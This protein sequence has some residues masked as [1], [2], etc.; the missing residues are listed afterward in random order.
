MTD[1]RTLI[2]ST[3]QVHD[4]ESLLDHVIIIDNSRVLLDSPI[5]DISRRYAFRYV[6]PQ[7]MDDSVIYAEPSLQGN[8]V[9]ML[10]GEGEEETQVNLE[11]LFNAT[12]GG[13]I[14]NK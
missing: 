11:L 2:I 13:K 6:S 1:D 7:E 10:R 5:A 4:I 12:I 8:A 9:I 3:H 14:T